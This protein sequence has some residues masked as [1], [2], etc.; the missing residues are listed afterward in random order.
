MFYYFIL[1]REGIEEKEESPGKE[2]SDES[3]SFNKTTRRLL[4]GQDDLF[5]NLELDAKNKK[6]SSI[7]NEHPFYKDLFGSDKNV[8]KPRE[9][10]KREIS[11]YE[12]MFGCFLKRDEKYKEMLELLEK[13]EEIIEKNLSIEYMVR[14]NF[15]LIF[16]KKILLSKD[17]KLFFRYNMKSINIPKPETTERFME[18][19]NHEFNGKITKEV[20]E[21]A[22]ENGNEHLLEEFADYHT[23]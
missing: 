3:L 13:C 16:L 11:P 4:I 1:G 12:L 18:E 9:R 10:N 19:L 8:S 17:E 22:E 23:N 20:I 21:K 6:Y 15:E 2:S 7:L 5:K 14:K